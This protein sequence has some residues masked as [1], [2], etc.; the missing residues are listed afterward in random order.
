MKEYREF[1]KNRNVEI[2]YCTPRVHTGNGVVE[3]TIQTLKNLI[4]AY[5]EDGLKLNRKRKQSILR[6]AIYNTYRIK[7][8]A[9]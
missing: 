2:E 1:C 5:L 6:N 8:N 7:I 4:I 3:R 9:I